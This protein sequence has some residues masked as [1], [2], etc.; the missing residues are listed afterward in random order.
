MQPRLI[1]EDPQ[2]PT[3]PGVRLVLKCKVCG[4]ERPYV[5]PKVYYDISTALNEKKRKQY[6]PLIIPQR[7]TCTKCGAVDQYEL[8]GMG[9]VAIM[10][11][12]VAASA[13]S[14][15]GVL[16]PDQQIKFLTFTTRW[17]EMHPDEAD[18]RYRN[19]LAQKPNDA[20][21]HVGYANQRRFLGYPDEAIARYEQALALDPN[22]AEAWVNLAQMAG[23]RRDMNEAI[24]CWEK[25]RE[26]SRGGKFSDLDA[27]FAATAEV[28]LVLLHRGVFPGDDLDDL[29]DEDLELALTRSSARGA[30]SQAGRPAPAPQAKIGRNEPCPCG[31]GK[32]Y[33]HCHGRK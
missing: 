7:V 5:F 33:K 10:A 9:H 28:N 21:L 14:A 13:P 12:M 11:N 8:S 30:Q 32:K 19:E 16:R 1:Y 29:D 22:N 3:E 24:R 31:S 2:P 23:E 4:R 17:G 18:E 6:D 15:K 20:D 25:V 26:T 27:D